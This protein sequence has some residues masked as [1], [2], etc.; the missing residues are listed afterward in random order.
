MIAGKGNHNHHNWSYKIQVT[1]SERI[2]T[3]NRQHIKPTSITAEEYIH[4]QAKKHTNRQT[5]QL[6]AILDHIKNN[7]QSYSNKTTHNNK[8]GHIW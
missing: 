8:S 1:T 4:Y 3:Q 2:I 7:P 6:D 5:D